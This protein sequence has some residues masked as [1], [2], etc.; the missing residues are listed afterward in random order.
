[1][2]FLTPFLY[3]VFTTAWLNN[4]WEQ[5]L[6]LKL[7]RLDV[8]FAYTQLKSNSER[9]TNLVKLTTKQI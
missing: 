8:L 9:S 1:M 4:Y 3:F 5:Y 7:T 2:G 6:L